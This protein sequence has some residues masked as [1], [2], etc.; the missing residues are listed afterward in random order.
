MFRFGRYL[1]KPQRRDY[2]L[3]DLEQEMKRKPQS[4]TEMLKEFKEDKGDAL[5]KEKNM[6]GMEDY[7]LQEQLKKKK[8]EDPR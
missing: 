6:Q 8:K 7:Y 4:D 1:S 3:I 2:E 5:I